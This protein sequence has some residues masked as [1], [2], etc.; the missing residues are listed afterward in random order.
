MR[1]LLLCICFV[2]ALFSRDTVFVKL[3]SGIGNQMFQLAAAYSLAKTINADLKVVLSKSE[4]ANLNDPND[5]QYRL[6]NDDFY[7]DGIKFV[8]EEELTKSPVS[9]VWEG[10]S[11]KVWKEIDGVKSEEIGYEYLKGKGRF[12]VASFFESEIFFKKHAKDIKKMFSLRKTNSAFIK[13]YLPEIKKCNSVAVHV[14]RGDFKN[15]PDRILPISYYI[16]AMQLFA[17]QKDVKFFVFSDDPA[18]VKDC[19]FNLKNVVIVS[20]DSDPATNLE[21]FYLM[22]Q[23]KHFIVANSTFSWWAAYLCSNANATI[24][25]PFPRYKDGYFLTHPE[26]IQRDTIKYLHETQSYP[27]H[28][29]SINPFELP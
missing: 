20:S 2:S 6:N 25:A 24:I 23:C 11:F 16:Q 22:T 14:R 1:Y 8:P 29:K 12:Q 9:F 15:F 28:W 21:E 13:K 3:D 10:T 5:R 27:K 26:G 19:F 18:Y 4:K 7:L 17:K